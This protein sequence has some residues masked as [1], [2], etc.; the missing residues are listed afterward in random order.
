MNDSVSVVVPVYN[1]E[2]YLPACVDSILAQTFTNMEVILVDDGSTDGCAALCD[3]YAHR[4]NRVRTIHRANGGLSAARNTGIEVAAGE[5]ITFIDSD[6]AVAP[7]MIEYLLALIK[8]YDADMS[9]CQRWYIDED[10]NTLP[11]P[12]KRDVATHVV[13]G[14]AACM[15]AFFT[16]GHI[17]TVAWAKLYRRAQFRTI[18]YPE[19]KYNEDVFTTYRVV[20][21]CNAIAVGAERKYL[22][23]QRRQSITKSSFNAKH[24]DSIEGNIIRRDFIAEH[25]PDCLP[26]AECGIVWALNNVAMR[27]ARSGAFRHE[28][29]AYMQK[30]YR[31]YTPT[32]LRGGNRPAAKAFALCAFV[33]LAA[34]LRIVYAVSR[35]LRQRN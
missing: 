3:E 7:D 32:F 30:Q 22:Y 29:V 21:E 5:Y 9:V 35:L 26:Q 18:R 23:R 16:H 27:M 12:A 34:T 33:S 13:R 11:M 31:K 28:Y 1:V 24:L 10:G 4:D 15:R 14:N 25:Y 2:A 19:G 17:D 8:E 20:A 6:D